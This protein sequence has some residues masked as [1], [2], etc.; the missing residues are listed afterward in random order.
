V[1]RVAW[2][3][4][5]PLVL[6]VPVVEG[7]EVERHVARQVLVREPETGAHAVADRDRLAHG[8]V[9]AEGNPGVQH[10]VRVAVRRRRARQ[11]GPDV[12]HRHGVRRDHAARLPDEQRSR[13]VDDRLRA[14]PCAHAPLDRLVAKLAAGPVHQV[15]HP[16]AH[17][18][19]DVWARALF[20]SPGAR[21]AFSATRSRR[22]SPS[23]GSRRR[24]RASA[25]SR[26]RCGAPRRARLP[27][28]RRGRPLSPRR[29]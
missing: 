11:L 2:V 18:R 26:A 8:G 25:R 13:A 5:D 19:P 23:A 6:L 12:L 17:W 22:P 14:E 16:C 28:H 27:P 7:G 15:L 10:A 21:P 9:H 29:V 24:S 20:Q 4:G 3:A 1:V